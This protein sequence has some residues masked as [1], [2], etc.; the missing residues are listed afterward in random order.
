MTVST[1]PNR[2]HYLERDD[3]RIAVE[4]DGTYVFRI[5]GIEPVALD[6]AGELFSFDD[7]S[8]TRGRLQPR[9]HVGRIRIAVRGSRDQGAVTL[10]VRPRKLDFEAEY[11]HMLDAIAEVATEA[12]L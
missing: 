1:L 4:E 12:I 3:D 5:D 10:T 2:A 9:Q 6:P 8:Q 7:D 11:R